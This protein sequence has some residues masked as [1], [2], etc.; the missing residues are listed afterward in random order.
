MD[1]DVSTMAV[2]PDEVPSVH[3]LFTLA[4]TARHCP[5][6]ILCATPAQFAVGWFGGGNSRRFARMAVR[7]PDPSGVLA[8]DGTGPVGWAACGP[9]SR[10][11][12]LER[13]E[14]TRGCSSGEGEWFVPCVFVADNARG[15]GVSHALVG[16]A[17]ELARERN[18]PS[19]AACPVAAT[20]D[21][22]AAAFTGRE[23]VFA[24]LGFHLVGATTSTRVLVRR[25]LDGPRR[26]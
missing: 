16:A 21:R 8:L 3:R 23:Q 7:D 15:R 13:S 19:I 18:A 22:S 4:R 5:C 12:G 20:V 1:A 2:G 9:R 24:D 6:M 14:A 26:E 25:E 17:V 11:P 10:Y